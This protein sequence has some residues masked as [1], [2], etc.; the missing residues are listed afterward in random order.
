MTAVEWKNPFSLHR[1]KFHHFHFLW[2]LLKA[3]GIAF[4]PDCFIIRLFWRRRRCCFIHPFCW[5]RLQ[6]KSTQLQ[7]HDV[8]CNHKKRLVNWMLVVVVDFFFLLSLSYVRSEYLVVCVSWSLV[9]RWCRFKILLSS[10]LLSNNSFFGHIAV[11]VD[12]PAL[13]RSFFISCPSN[14]NAF[15][16]RKPVIQEREKNVAGEGIR[17]IFSAFC[18]S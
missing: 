9:K 16:N 5:M 6:F 17:F 10:I 12:C 13:F 18:S 1:T 11:S 15:N 7:N 3:F 4:L 8:K 2:H 14:S